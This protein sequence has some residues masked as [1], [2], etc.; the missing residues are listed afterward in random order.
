M[1]CLLKNARLPV[2]SEFRTVDISV[3]DGRIV[4]IAGGL[5]PAPGSVAIDLHHA[6]VFP[7][8]VDV[9][10]HLREPGFSYK[11][12]VRTGTLSAAK[13]GYAHVCSMPNL[14]P[15]PDCL[16]HLR[17]QLDIIQR[18]AAV[19]VHPYG[20]ITRGERGET[21]SDMEEMSPYTAGFSDDGRG[22]QNGNIM[23]AAMCGAK[24]LGKIIAAHCEDN[25]LLHGGYIHDGNYARANGHRGICSE[26]EWGQIARD[27]KLA[28][29][30][31]CKYHVCHISTRE[32]VDIIRR[33][34][35]A[36]V[37]V[38]CETGPHYLVFCDDDLQE[39]GWFKMNPPIRSNKDRTALIEGLL[40]GTIDM[41]ATDH[42]PHSLEEKS[43][44]LEKSAMGVVGL[45]TAFPAVYTHLVRSGV[46]PLERLVELF[47][48]NPARRFGFGTPLEPGQP[49]DLTV[50]DLDRPFTVDPDRFLTMGRATPFAG[51][52]LYGVC[53]LTMVDGK[54]V[55]REEDL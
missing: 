36:G 34:K 54:I 33:A 4:S 30:T 14:D 42:A 49:A 5:C 27:L 50:F 37:D 15:V 16:E 21:L 41:I 52:R 18:D 55:W 8:F 3:A 43:R 20:S 31:G 26:S 40:D 45:E 47:H 13:G 12:T 29:E 2:G 23:R 10:V 35:S 38:T 25:A 19:H 17:V 24:R 44:G 6:V 22:V 11:E 51:M 32:S 28:A 53:M 7:G 48:D 46:L 9:H 1:N 39:D